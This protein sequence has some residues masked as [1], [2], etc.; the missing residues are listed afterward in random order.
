LL[1]IDLK[2]LGKNVGP[3]VEFLRSR[4]DEPVRVKRSQVRLTDTNARTAK[5][6][7]RKF[8]RQFRPEGYRVLSV[9]SGL[10]EVRAPEKEKPRPAQPVEGAKPSVWETIPDLWYTTPP[11]IIRPAKRSKREMKRMMRGL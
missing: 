9:N 8:L 4:L 2:E 7:L 5:L 6:L 3:A 1:T 11:G 10:I